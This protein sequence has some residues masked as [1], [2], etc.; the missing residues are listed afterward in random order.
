LI[1]RRRVIATCVAFAATAAAV[2]V[3]TLP[4]SAAAQYGFIRQYAYI[5]ANYSGS[6]NPLNGVAGKVFVAAA[7]DTFTSI[8]GHYPHVEMNSSNTA[9]SDASYVQFGTFQGRI[10]NVRDFGQSDPCYTVERSYSAPHAM[11]IYRRP[12]YCGG[13]E[14]AVDIGQFGSTNNYRNFGLRRN[15]DGTYY[16]R[17][18]DQVVYTTPVTLPA[19]MY[20]N[21]GTDS[22]DT[23]ATN[24][25]DV[26]DLNA[27]GG[28][29]L[30]LHDNVQGWRYWTSP[31]RYYTLY[32]NQSASNYSLGTW[33]GRTDNFYSRGPY[34]C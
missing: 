21:V 32:Q 4:A 17:L 34:A 23:C 25:G 22:N 20:P 14:I 13:K 9:T 33:N 27:T 12:D 29:T 16:G 15:S 6:G 2:I 31:H 24:K 3:P 26:Y 11:M 19:A 28:A 7:S 5:D 18:D 10:S 8:S 1:G 30:I